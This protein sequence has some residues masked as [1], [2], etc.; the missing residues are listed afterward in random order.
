MLVDNRDGCKR[1]ELQMYICRTLRLSGNVGVLLYGCCGKSHGEKLSITF[2]F[3]RT[4][5]PEYPR[6]DNIVLIFTNNDANY[7][8][9]R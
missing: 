5:Y 1:S 8:R 3:S 4:R 9:H 7:F 2:D 6:E